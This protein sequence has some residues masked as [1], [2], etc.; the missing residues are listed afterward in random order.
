[1]PV[2]PPCI[3][4]SL[5]LPQVTAS[6]GYCHFFP[7]PVQL[8]LHTLMDLSSGCIQEQNDAMEN[9]A[10]L[11]PSSVLLCVGFVPGGSLLTGRMGSSSLRPASDQ[12]GHRGKR[13]RVF[14]DHLTG[15][16]YWKTWAALEPIAA[17]GRW[18]ACK[19]TQGAGLE[20][21]LWDCDWPE[22]RGE[23]GPRLLLS[24]PHPSP[25]L[26]LGLVFFSWSFSEG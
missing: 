23:Q 19:Y 18:K 25:P 8:C 7:G 4:L 16:C 9:R 21:P 3:L 13:E 17:A 15:S 5:R 1:M 6:N 2:Q 24:P 22:A 26:P 12:H 11:S 10:L 14:L 20:R